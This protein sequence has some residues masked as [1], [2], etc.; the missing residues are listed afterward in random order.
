MEGRLCSTY[1]QVDYS[2]VDC[3]LA[4]A[5]IQLL[6]SIPVFFKIFFLYYHYFN[7][8]APEKV[9]LSNDSVSRCSQMQS[10]SISI[11]GE[12]K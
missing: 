10:G 11:Y 9:E 6:G 2:L 3:G 1:Y 8:T 12:A 4:D 5:V 7:F